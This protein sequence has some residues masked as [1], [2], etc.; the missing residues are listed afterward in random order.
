MD[1]TTTTT[2]TTEG[3]SQVD[4]TSGS[5]H[6]VLDRASDSYADKMDKYFEIFEVR[7]VHVGF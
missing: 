5:V 2:S 6:N 3:D 4:E 7:I 1:P